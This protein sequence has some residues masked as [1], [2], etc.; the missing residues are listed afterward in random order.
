MADSPYDREFESLLWLKQ[1]GFDVDADL[2]DLHAR[3]H[4]A[5]EAFKAVVG[6][7]EEPYRAPAVIFDEA[8]LTDPKVRAERLAKAPL[9]RFDCHTGTMA[10]ADGRIDQAD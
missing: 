3:H 5:D 6:D 9:H 4:E 2:A 7:I 1:R 10:W 8:H